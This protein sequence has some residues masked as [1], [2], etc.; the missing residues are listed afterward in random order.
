MRVGAVSLLFKKGDPAD[1]KNWRP[2]TL[3]GADYKVLAR[4]LT[5]RLR[6]AMPHVVHED[7][8][9]GVE[10]R[11]GFFNLQVVRDAISWVED[12]GLPLA[13]VSLDQ[14]K[15]FDRVSHAFLFKV[16]ERKGFG[17]YFLRW[18]RVM[19]TGV[20]SRVKVNRHLGDCI[21]QTR[22][23][24]QGCPLSPLLY[25]L[26][27]EPLAEAL[28]ANPRVEGLWVPGGGGVPLKVALY[29][30]DTT[31]F[32]T[33]DRSVAEAL[34]VCGEFGRA[35]GSALNIG[36]SQLKF[37]GRWAARGDSLGG[38]GACEGP[39][40]VLGVDFIAGDSSALN[41]ATRIAAV[42]RRMGL[43]QQRKLTISGK[44]LVIKADVLPRLVYLGCVFP[45]PAWLR[46][47]LTRAVFRFLWGSYEYVQRAQMYQ[48]VA[49][50]GRDVPCLPLKLD[51]LFFSNLCV[52]LAQPVLHKFQLFV[53][54]YMSVSLRFMCPGDNLTPRA[55][56]LP[57]HYSP[58]LRWA[59]RHEECWDPGLVVVHRRLYD[60]LQI[61]MKPVGHLGV[62]R[63]VWGRLQFGSLGNRLRDLNWLLVLN[64]L[65]VRDILYRHGISVNCFCPRGDCM[66]IETV[67]HT[68]WACRF[69]QRVWGGAGRRFA[70][71]WG[72]T[73]RGVLF[74]DGWKGWR[75]RERE[76][77]ILVISLYK[78]ALWDARCATVRTRVNAGVRAVQG[79]VGAE[80]EWRFSIAKGRWGFHAAKER[81]K[82]V[83]DGLQRARPD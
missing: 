8:T 45:L 61:K 28:R 62:S 1:L 57:A 37:F 78:K 43:W 10:G 24:R 52:S 77:V 5:E 59:R 44:I 82:V 12:R 53:R 66:R 17:K 27:L 63:E 80:L 71:L 54:F 13:L 72:L 68:F 38:L 11:S 9:C 2:L 39:L 41:W 70:A 46:G 20:G 81:W 35:S 15:A 21:L 49:E 55:G 73:E 25:V 64:R 76:Q 56:S 29:A 74:G 47:G 3:L 83:W 6:L 48:P 30:D 79:W 36:K 18:L 42:R 23:V 22:G 67:Q 32:L 69:A 60:R 4:V 51:V 7:Q 50:G 31:L 16:L 58:L 33:A 19:Y 14:E 26:Y 34:R 65:P 75:I 40:R